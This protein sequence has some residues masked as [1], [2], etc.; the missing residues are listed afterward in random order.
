MSQPPK[1]TIL[2]PRARWV[3]LRMVFC[4]MAAGTWGGSPQLSRAALKY[5]RRG[6]QARRR[7]LPG[8]ASS[9]G[10]YGV[11]YGPH[12]GAT[13]ADSGGFDP[14][15]HAVHG[16]DPH[17]R[18]RGEIGTLDL[19]ER[20]GDLHAPTPIDDRPL[21]RHHATDQRLGASVEQGLV[22]AARASTEPA[23]VDLDRDEAEH[24]EQRDLCQH[25]EVEQQH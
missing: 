8:P 25:R 22:A 23:P 7:A 16:H 2:A 17:R 1:S 15:A 4:V 3:S 24:D 14:Q 19:P 9:A 10:P 20:I 21:Q 11:V 12:S 5:A 13:A 6:N 18:A